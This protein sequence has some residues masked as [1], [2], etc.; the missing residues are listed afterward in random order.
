MKSKKWIAMA[1]TVALTLSLA[2]S[3]VATSLPRAPLPGDDTHEPS[4]GERDANGSTTIGIMQAK[5]DPSNMSF[6]V[7]LYVTMAVVDDDAVVKV[8]TNYSI[9]NTTTPD[10]GKEQYQN[11]GVVGMSF[12][13]LGSSTFN[14]VA[15]NPTDNADIVLSI[16]GVVMPTLS[17]AGVSPVTLGGVFV[18]SGK[19]KPIPVTVG[20]NELNLPL[21]GTVASATRAEAATVAQ[22]KVKYTL[23]ML[24]STGEAMGSVYAGDDA[25]AAGMPGLIVP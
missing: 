25:N 6:E 1:M 16:G 11:I 7:P 12:E 21:V 22:F 23:S 13:K 5:V 10:A 24:S 9:K 4:Q 8:P 19:P 18:D 15:A 20:A 17:S 3:A 14:T 2:T